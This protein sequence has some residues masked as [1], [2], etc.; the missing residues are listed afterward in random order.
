VDDLSSTLEPRDPGLIG[1]NNAGKITAFNVISGFDAPSFGRAL[2]EGRDIS[3]L[4]TG[5]IAALGLA[6]TLQQTALFQELTVLDN[7]LVGCHPQG[8]RSRWRSC[9]AAPGSRRRRERRPSTRSS[10]SVS[11][12]GGAAR[13]QPPARPAAGAR[14]RRGARGGPR[15]C[16]STS[17]SPA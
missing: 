2:F 5:G 8:A 17:R 16:C 14:P 9:W 6:R 3:G 15:C 13:V 12:G 7:V 4:R 10:P 11:P 1:P